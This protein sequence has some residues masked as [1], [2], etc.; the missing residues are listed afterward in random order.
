MLPVGL[1]CFFLPRTCCR[2]PRENAGAAASDTLPQAE[3]RRQ[4][5]HCGRVRD[6][7]GRAMVCEV[8]TAN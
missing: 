4:A 8:C 3:L 2:E 6:V 5:E 1:A 7:N